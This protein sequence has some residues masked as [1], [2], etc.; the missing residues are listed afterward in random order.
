MKYRLMVS[1][2]PV[3]TVIITSYFLIRRHQFLTLCDLEV[4][5]GAFYE[6]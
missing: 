4:F 5:G 2:I 3:G 6:I 1:E